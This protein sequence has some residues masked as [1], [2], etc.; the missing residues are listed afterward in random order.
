MSLHLRKTTPDEVR[1]IRE[2]VMDRLMT[3]QMAIEKLIAGGYLSGEAEEI[4]GMI[5]YALACG[6]KWRTI[7]HK[8]KGFDYD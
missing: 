4:I 1:A 6:S 7:T 3:P 5:E 2:L 8:S